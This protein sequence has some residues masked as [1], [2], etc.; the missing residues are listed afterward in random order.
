[1][2][3]SISS[4]NPRS[5][6]QAV[7]LSFLP[8]LADQLVHRLFPKKVPASISETTSILAGVATYIFLIHQLPLHSSFKIAAPAL[9]LAYKTAQYYWKAKPPGANIAP[10]ALKPAPVHAK[11]PGVIAAP[12]TLMPRPAEAQAPLSATAIL[13]AAPPPADRPK[14]YWETKYVARLAIPLMEFIVENGS[15]EEEGIYRVSGN[16]QLLEANLY[17]LDCLYP[18]IQSTTFKID[19]LFLDLRLY[20]AIP[21]AASICKALFGRLEDPLLQSIM[22]KLKKASKELEAFKKLEDKAFKKLEEA[23][24]KESEQQKKELASDLKDVVVESSE[25]HEEP[26]KSNAKALDNFELEDSEELQKKKEKASTK[27]EAA[28]KT[29]ER[30]FTA[31]ISKLDQNRKELLHATL[32][33]LRF[34]AGKPAHKMDSNNLA[35]I[36]TPLFFN[37][38]QLSQVKPL[39]AALAYLIDNALTLKGH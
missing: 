14:I 27:L 36:F 39:S 30:K 8:A 23:K 26:T 7:G 18:T 13:A 4:F 12:P 2:A 29:V 10:P 21:R 11:P 16:N 31:A 22:K 28:K 24:K 1:M 34:I 6:W 37:I 17:Y 9:Y 25:E 35:I 5:S 32:L 3:F 38:P 19:N 20:L 33:H 15:N